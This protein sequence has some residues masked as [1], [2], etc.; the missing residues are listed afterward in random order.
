MRTHAATNIRRLKVE[1]LPI[2]INVP[3]KVKVLDSTEEYGIF[4]IPNC[5]KG[6]NMDIAARLSY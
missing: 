6:Y 5:D 3:L 4:V 2:L 1:M